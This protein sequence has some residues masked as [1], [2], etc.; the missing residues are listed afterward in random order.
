MA[1]T[2]V[3][4]VGNEEYTSLKEVAAVLGVA[5]VSKK[6]IEAGKYPEVS[7]QSVDEA[8]LAIGDTDDTPRDLNEGDHMGIYDDANEHGAPEED[9]EDVGDTPDV[10]KP[11][12][13]ALIQAMLDKKNSSK[14]TTTPAPTTDDVEYPE[15][16]EFKDVKAMKKYI[17]KLS[18]SQLQEWCELE[19]A[20]WK[21]NEHESI[22]RMRMAMAIKA[23]HFPDTAPKGNGAKKKSKYGDYTTEQLVQM[24]MDN[25]IEVRDAKGDER[26]ERMY[27]IMALKSAGLLA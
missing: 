10:P 4:V 7:T 14:P 18:D 5:K 19:G 23:I 20:T 9:T 21:P 24:A 12:A 6:D 27:T 17:K 15:V 11:D 16:G 1:N 3:Y 8:Y 2:T 22:N 25:D 26:I 13:K